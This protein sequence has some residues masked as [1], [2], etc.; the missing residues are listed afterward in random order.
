MIYMKSVWNRFRFFIF[1]DKNKGH[2]KIWAVSYRH[3][4]I[5]IVSKTLQIGDVFV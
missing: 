4:V 5:E 3:F 2:M 1:T